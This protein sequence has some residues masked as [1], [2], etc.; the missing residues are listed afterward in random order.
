M[1]QGLFSALILKKRYIV[2]ITLLTVY[3]IKENV[4]PMQKKKEK[5]RGKK[6]RSG[7]GTQRAVEEGKLKKKCAWHRCIIV[8]RSLFV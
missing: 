6:G 7:I 2:I 1:K 4:K 5:G 8:L 3:Q